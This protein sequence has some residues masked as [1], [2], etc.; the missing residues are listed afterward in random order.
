MMGQVWIFKEKGGQV[1][2]KDL[3]RMSIQK[4]SA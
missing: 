2:S 4:F 1:M 3:E